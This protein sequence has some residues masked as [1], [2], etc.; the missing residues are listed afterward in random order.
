RMVLLKGLAHDGFVFYTNLAS[1]KGAELTANP[2]CAL[3]FPW[4]QLERQVRVEGVA[5]S[6][7]ADEVAAYFASRPRGAQ[8]GAWASQ[9]SQPVASRAELEGAVARM[10][11]RF[12]EGDVPVPPSWGGYVVVPE[13][14]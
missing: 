5:T 1:R 10:E 3:L 8:I 4:H 11:E 14:V 9:Q 6:L 12:G 2:R 13:V 7:P